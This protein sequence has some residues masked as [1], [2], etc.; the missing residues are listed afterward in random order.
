L[1][2]ALRYS[3]SAGAAE[4]AA[5]RLRQSSPFFRRQLRCS[6]LHMGTPKASQTKQQVFLLNVAVD[7]KKSQKISSVR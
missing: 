6:A 1:P 4:L 3:L 5:A 7:Q 2:T